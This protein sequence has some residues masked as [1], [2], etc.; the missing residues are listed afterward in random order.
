MTAKP[1]DAAPALAVNLVDGGAFDLNDARPQTFEMLVFYR[2]LHCPVCKTY[3]SDLES[4]L[5]EFAKR[6]V[7]V[8]ALSTDSR[9]R[10]A[11]SKS[12]WGLTNLRL[13]CELPIATARS[14]DLFISKAIRDGEPSEFSEP[15]LF[16][17]KPD[18]T[19]FFASR[20]S[21]PWGRP[22]LDQ[23]LRGIDVAVE[24]KMPARGEA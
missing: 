24:R 14:W 9:E 23:M 6:G 18:R 17:V 22:P 2:G 4:K 15:G 21:A 1:R 13:G 11:R 20:T 12:E 3:L 5:P 16:L 10:A 7:D 8:I 19:L